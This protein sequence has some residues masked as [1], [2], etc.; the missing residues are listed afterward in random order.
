MCAPS[1]SSAP[2]HATTCCS[3]PTAKT[4]RLFEADG[5]TWVIC[6]ALAGASGL[7]SDVLLEA[8]G[9]YI[10]RWLEPGDFPN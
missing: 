5:T 8:M 7:T 9:R 10:A 4:L 3:P 6:P 2:A 1:A